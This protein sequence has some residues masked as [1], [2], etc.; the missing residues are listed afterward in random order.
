MKK[1]WLA[2]LA[3]CGLL[4]L[5][6]AGGAFACISAEGGEPVDDDLKTNCGGTSEENVEPKDAMVLNVDSIDFGYFS[7]VGK[8]YTQ[9][10]SIENKS[11]SPINVKLS[12]LAPDNADIDGENKKASDWIVFVG[13]VRYFE[14]PAKGTK[15][16]GV[17]VMVPADAKFGSQYAVIKVENVTGEKAEELDVKMTVATEGVA[18]G[19]EVAS[20]V[21]LPINISDKANVGLTVKNN[22]NAGFEAKYVARVSPRFGLEKWTDIVDES[23]EVYPGANVSF[24][25]SDKE[26]GFG[27]FMVEQKIV[28][29]NSN[30]ERVEE[31]LK[32]TVLN[33]PMW[34]F[35]VL[36]GIVVLAIVI[37]IVIHIIRKKKM[38]DDKDEF[39][40]GDKKEKKSK[41]GKKQKKAKAKKDD[42]GADS[43][44]MKV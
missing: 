28:Y 36:G 23:K 1:N 6:I 29:V 20:G 7:E 24:S 37:A 41:H 2:G 31:V 11:S 25:I 12:A 33:V 30:G 38:D 43:V 15:V 35:F 9:T 21:A 26:I 5:S 4:S 14:V 40:E 16:V 10:F 17:R 22:G 42:G 44:D 19:G 13:G 34:I 32:G 3:L 27:F 18:F 39:D 8:S